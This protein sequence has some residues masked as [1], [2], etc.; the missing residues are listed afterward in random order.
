MSEGSPRS[1]PAAFTEV[2]FAEVVWHA[3]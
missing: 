3:L 1:T 2:P